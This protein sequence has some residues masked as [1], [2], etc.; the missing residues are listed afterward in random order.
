[1]GMIGLWF[2]F[3][4]L[5]IIKLIFFNKVGNFHL[6]NLIIIV[7][8]LL[9]EPCPVNGSLLWYDQY[10]QC[11]YLCMELNSGYIYKLNHTHIGTDYFKLVN[12]QGMGRS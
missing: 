6:N 8:F 9:V 3:K 1:M 4:S 2:Y 11:K 7:G 10:S 5:F 12:K